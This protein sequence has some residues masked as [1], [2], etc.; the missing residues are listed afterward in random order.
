MVWSCPFTRDR[1]LAP[2]RDADQRVLR[3]G[4]AYV[5]TVPAALIPNQFGVATNPL[6]LSSVHFL[7]SDRPLNCVSIVVALELCASAA[8]DDQRYSVDEED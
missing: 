5:F 1:K 6:I 8:K 3:S 4:G 7:A 2:S